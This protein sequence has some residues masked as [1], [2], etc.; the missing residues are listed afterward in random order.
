MRRKSHSKAKISRKVKASQD[1]HPLVIRTANWSLKLKVFNQS[2]IQLVT[3]L[4]Q[5]NTA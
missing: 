5:A 1:R 2:L 3:H 4:R